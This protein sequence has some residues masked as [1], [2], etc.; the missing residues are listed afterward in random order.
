MN[1][2]PF[3]VS[4][5]E[6]EQAVISLREHLLS[7]RLTLEEFSE[8]VG[9]ALRASMSGDLAAVGQD[10][11]AASFSVGLSRRKPARF[12]AA[13]FGHAVRRGQLRLRGWIV[14]TAVAGDLDLDLR[15]AGIDKPRTVATVLLAFG[16]VDVYVPEGVTVEVSGITFV[17][18]L[19]E[20]GPDNSAAG[21]PVIHVRAVGCFATVDVWRVPRDAPRDYSAIIAR[22]S[23]N[24]RQPL[25]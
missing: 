10:L 8:R 25:C 15:E 3:R 12:A 14:A 4:D 13:V 24:E 17:G 7:G 11:P 22:V 16:N 18:H 1:D 23:D 6:R 20:R 5:A 2:P 21:A 19:R 9:S